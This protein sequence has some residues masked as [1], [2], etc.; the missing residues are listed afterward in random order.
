MAVQT[1]SSP[2]D[3][4]VNI[5]IEP[6]QTIAFD[7]DIST[8]SFERTGNDLTISVD[9]GG[10]LVLS[11]FFVG[12]DSGSLPGLQLQDGT[13]VA[14]NDFL[15]AMDPNFDIT[16]AAGPAASSNSSGINSYA[17]AAGDLV[18][19]LG[20]SESLDGIF[21]S[22][23]GGV[24][25]TI[26]P[27]GAVVPAG[28]GGEPTPPVPTPDQD[29]TARAVL[30]TNNG[31]ADT[32]NFRLAN[33][34][35]FASASSSDGL[36]DTT[37]LIG[38]NADGSYSLRSNAMSG[39][40]NEYDYVTIYYT[41]G[42]SEVIQVILNHDGTFDSA[43]EDALN[44]PSAPIA[45]EWHTQNNTTSDNGSRQTS[46]GNDEI[47]LKTVM[48][49]SHGSQGNN[50]D[51][52]AG[53]DQVHITQGV[54]AIGNSN[55]IRSGTGAGNSID[56]SSN[57]AASAGGSNYIESGRIIV[58]NQDSQ[59]T[60][61][62]AKSIGS[63][64]TLIAGN[65]GPNAGE[66]AITLNSD[67][68]GDIRISP[69]VVEAANGGK[70]NLTAEGN[71]GI[72]LSGGIK[73]AG[74]NTDPRGIY[75][76]GT[77]SVNTVISNA[78]GIILDIGKGTGTHHSGLFAKDH[79][80]NILRADSG[81]VNIKVE[82]DGTGDL[83][84]GDTHYA[85]GVYSEA[86]GTNTVTGY[87]IKVGAGNSLNAFGVLANG[88]TNT[89][90]ASNTLNISAYQADIASGVMADNS[91]VNRLS[92]TEKMTVSAYGSGAY[93]SEASAMKT[94][95]NG[96]NILKS[97][98]NI[99]LIAINAG[100]HAVGIQ[101]SAA[102][103][104]AYHNQV[105]ADGT[106]RIDVRGGTAWGMSA[107]DDMGGNS[108]TAAKVVINATGLLPSDAGYATGMHAQ[109]GQ[110]VI[111]A[112]D[113]SVTAAT[114]ANGMASAMYAEDG[115]FNKIM[116]AD[117]NEAV[118][119]TITAQ[120][121]AFA[122]GFAMYAQTS[123]VN[124]ILGGNLG[125][126][127]TING[128][129]GI[130]SVTGG[131]NWIETG[132]GN[133]TIILN[134]KIGVGALHI[135]AGAD[136]DTLVLKAGSIAE[137]NT[138]YKDWLSDT[139]PG[140]TIDWSMMGIEAVRVEV[141]GNIDLSD[142]NW[143]N[144]VFNGSGT[145]F[146][147]D[148]GNASAMSV[149][150]AFGMGAGNDSFSLVGNVDFQGGLIDGGAGMDTLK[151]GELADNALDLSA[152]AS[153][154]DGFE[155]IDLTGGSGTTLTIDSLLDGLNIDTQLDSSRILNDSSNCDLANGTVLRVTGDDND[156]VTVSGQWNSTA[157][158]TVQYDGVTYNVYT[159]TD[160]MDQYLLVQ[161]S[162]LA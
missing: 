100:E 146:I 74:S 68:Q 137:F 47:W 112:N 20:G 102:T 51:T 103:D 57:V 145:D 93:S 81:T 78:A 9:G 135:D 134:G 125:D 105:E 69:M 107:V 35:T 76:E 101:A 56:I 115:G 15:S 113:V 27:T 119:V 121:G 136:Y 140:G 133:D 41:D 17:D 52:G 109:N 143:M 45:G 153:A 82:S 11:G 111:E 157:A 26:L 22:G 89:L 13:E 158:G 66:Y 120:K 33:G 98:S 118:I 130:H 91:G 4:L 61:L 6:G 104:Y 123:G 159:N 18:G 155:V 148:A 30:Y 94:M 99:D 19:G 149:V 71:I 40:A 29:Y 141:N 2:K 124:A 10:Q 129:V 50:I 162:L 36:V 86:S 90:T 95:G 55:S 37:S 116:A 5:S 110:N 73:Y 92:S 8:A 77:G 46:D 70:N 14:S 88:G 49:P 79:G 59:P 106:V 122:E 31:A 21:W 1:I 80:E 48:A 128:D 152:L 3:E 117:L 127:V 114:G 161:T 24:A 43:A 151:I 85:R 65:D 28:G 42:T 12:D 34:K 75:S 7:F 96:T 132:Q 138:N 87:D 139:G 147:I 23:Q 58:E 38:P 62:S 150:G 154:V 131:S 83:F 64:N 126:T 67:Y 142:L 97:Q 60:T 16:P 53:E 32:F 84:T 156:S 44:P 160:N 25:E 108:I 144:G 39:T 63:S 72:S 54:H